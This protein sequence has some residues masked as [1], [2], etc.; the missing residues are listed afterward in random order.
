MKYGEE[1]SV[2]ILMSTYNGEKYLH[3]QV[4][5]ILAQLQPNVSL[6]VR[7]DGSSDKT[8]EI[9]KNYADDNKLSW[10]AGDNLGCAKSFWHLLCN[11]QQADYYAFC[12]QDDVWDTDKIKIAVER[13]S[14]EN[15]DIPLLYCSKVRATDK[16]LNFKYE[17]LNSDIPI[18]Y[19]HSLIRN[20][21]PGCTY[22]FNN[23]LREILKRYDCDNYGIDIHDWTV[24][25]I[26]A[27]FGKVIF[28]NQT[29]MSYRQHENNEIGASH[30]DVFYW[31]N[32]LKRFLSGKYKKTRSTGARRLE[33]CYGEYMSNENK[34]YTHVMAHYMESFKNKIALLK[35]TAFKFNG[36]KYWSFKF[37]IWINK[38]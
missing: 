15:S 37:L 9:L 27:C 23:A 7:D 36:L 35:S 6:I 12:D 30:E 28:D 19:P 18:D 38:L 22:V 2:N 29:H 20:I 32:A 16:D 25:K 13:L 26:A 10:Y 4:E 5:S 8:C 11:C 1:M 14:S 3:E 17:F 21:A 34:I 31:I 24:Y 33:A